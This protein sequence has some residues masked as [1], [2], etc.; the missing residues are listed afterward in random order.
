MKKIYF[1]FLLGLSTLFLNGCI[2]AAVGLGAGTVAYVN[3]NYSMNMD[4]GVI[5]VYNAALKA[6]EA[7]NNYIISSK[8]ASSEKAEIKG[9]T[10]VDST[11]FKIEIEKITDNASKVTIKFGVFGDQSQSATLM[12]S[13][14]NNTK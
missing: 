13:I 9:S 12:T 11:K 7:N 1:G 10:K 2:V 5:K 4:G 14:D 3:G 6:L 8:E